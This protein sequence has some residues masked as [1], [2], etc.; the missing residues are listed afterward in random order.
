MTDY[1]PGTCNINQSESRKRY[2]V[3]VAGISAALLFSIAYLIL[4][5]ESYM[6]VFVFIAA[7]VGFQGFLQGRKN[8]CVAHARKG[9]RKTA[10][11]TEEVE[12]D[13]DRTEDLK[14]ANRIIAESIVL[15]ISLSLSVYLS[16]IML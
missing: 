3:G 5:S 2:F 11:E 7:T 8:F 16:G 10:E 13:E 12:D 15:G 1:Q 6:L 4:S 14:T 9:T